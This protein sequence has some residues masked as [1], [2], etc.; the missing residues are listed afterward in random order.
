MLRDVEVV[1]DGNVVGIKFDN[2]AAVVGY[3]AHIIE[4]LVVDTGVVHIDV[5]E[6]W[7]EDVANDTHGA[8]FLFVD[9]CRCI[10]LLCFSE[11]VLP[12]FHQSLEFVVQLCHF[13]AFGR[14]ANDNTK[15][16][17]LNAFDDL[18]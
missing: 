6:R 17:G 11:A 5:F 8:A 12:T 14:G 16:L 3:Q 13:F 15:I 9:E 7:T 4:N 18:A 2:V 1:E 10:E